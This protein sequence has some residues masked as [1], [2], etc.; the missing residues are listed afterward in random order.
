MRFDQLTLKAQEAFQEADSLARKYNTSAIEIEH[1]VMA[2]LDQDDGVI[3]PLIERIGVPV[4]DVTRSTEEL[5]KQRPK[6]YG[7]NAQ[8]T[9]SPE[10]AAVMAKAEQ[11]AD[12]LKDE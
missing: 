4:A 5:L 6:V 3:P 9:I 8:I 11:E 1:L 10:L 12:K 2:M 7:D